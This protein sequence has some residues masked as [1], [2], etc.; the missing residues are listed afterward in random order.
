MKWSA[1]AM[2]RLICNSKTTLCAGCPDTVTIIMPDGPP[3]TAGDEMTCSSDGYPDPTYTWTVDGDP[4]STTSTQTL[5]EGGHVFVC[6]ATVTHNGQTC[7]E[8]DTRTET[9][10]SKYKSLFLFF[11][12]ICGE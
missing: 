1:S 7:S 2:L 10:H 4:G 12:T 11:S 9:A 3:Y 5:Q 6:T 8:T